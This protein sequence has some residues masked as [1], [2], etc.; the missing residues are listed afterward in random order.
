M[1][2]LYPHQ[3]QELAF[4][5]QHPRALLLS[6]MGTGKTPVMCARAGEVLSAG[7]RVLLVTEPGLIAQMM[8]QADHWLPEGCPRPVEWNGRDTG[9]AFIITTHTKAQ[10]AVDSFCAFAPTLLIVDEAQIVGRGGEDQGAPIYSA[11]RRISEH[12]RGA[13]LATASPVR[14]THAL[15]LLA[16]MEVACLPGV[17][18]REQLA[19]HIDTREVT[20]RWGV[21]TVSEGITDQGLEMLLEPLRSNAIRHTLDQL[22]AGVVPQLIVREPIVV[23]LTRNER[24]AYE[25]ANRG[26]GLQRHHARTKV[27]RSVGGLTDAV[28]NYL[29]ESEGATHRKKVVFTENFDLLHPL[30]TAL[31]RRRISLWEITGDMTPKQRDANVAASRRAYDGVLIGTEA[32][33]TGLDLQHCSV[34]VSVIQSWNPERERQREGRLV[35]IGSQHN[36]VVHQ[37]IRPDVPLELWK[38]TKRDMKQQLADRV[39]KSVPTGVAAGA[40]HA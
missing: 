16:L 25:A 4:L 12:S 10:R 14:S 30:T 40:T 26:E 7:G 21:R 24:E 27:S 20:T 17:P 6:G 13:L 8:R 34:L 18:S 39:L 1:P 29:T 36:V 28:I 15:E 38:D 33:E 35:R 5:H 19:P 31:Q 2:D 23:A 9:T 32:I 37:P 3:R 11:L 22:G